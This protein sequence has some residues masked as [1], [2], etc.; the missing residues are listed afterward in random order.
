MGIP[1]WVILA[2]IGGLSSNLFN[3]LSRYVLREKDD[4][5]SWAWFYEV[6]RLPVFLIISFFDFKLTLTLYS[7][8]LLVLVGITEWVSVYLYMKMHQYSHLSI[9]TILSRTRLIWIPLIGFLFMKEQLELFE[10]VGI[11]LLFAGVATTVAPHKLFV[12]KGAVYANLAAIVIA[13]NVVLLKLVTP[14]ASAS[15]ILFFYS[16]PAVLLFPLI[17]RNAKVR[18]LASARKQ[19]P[20]KVIAMLAS[21][22]AGYFFIWALQTGDVSKVNGIYQGMMATGVLAG[23]IF[24]KEREGIVRKI[25]GTAFAVIGVLMLV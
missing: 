3:F 12:D 6:M 14:F 20:L 21:V 1:V 16:L 13:V 17:M 5:T 24:L 2:V 19:F 10:Y 18:L 11:V 7:A 8:V 22:V 25:I 15:V 4:S 23:I 9:S